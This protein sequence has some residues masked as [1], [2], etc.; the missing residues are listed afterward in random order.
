[1]ALRV[2]GVGYKIAESSAIMVG[3]RNAKDEA[4]DNEH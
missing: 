1:M 2:I 3:T 4:Q